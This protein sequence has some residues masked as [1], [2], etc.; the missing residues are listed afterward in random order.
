MNTHGSHLCCSARGA[1]GG[2]VPCSSVYIHSPHRQ[3]L[4]ARDSNSHPFDYDYDSLT[5]RLRL[6]QSY[7]YGEGH[8]DI[9]STFNFN[10]HFYTIKKLQ[11]RN[12]WF[13]SSESYPSRPHAD[14]ARYHRLERVMSRLIFICRSIIHET[15]RDVIYEQRYASIFSQRN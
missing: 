2:S 1:V 7:Q 5:I 3:F 6:H 13:V 15:M 4:P 9:T 11:V 14:F 12:I 10:A 8:S